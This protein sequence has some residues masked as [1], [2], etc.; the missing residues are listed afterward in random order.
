MPD[1]QRSNG[2]GSKLARLTGTN[3]DI[4]ILDVEGEKED[5]VTFMFHREDDILRL[6]RCELLLLRAFNTGQVRMQLMDYYQLVEIENTFN[7]GDKLL[8]R[9]GSCM[10]GLDGHKTRPVVPEDRVR[11]WME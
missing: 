11:G 9:V 7:D 3:Y 1:W 2:Y 10:G 6:S 4:V 8:H 5:F